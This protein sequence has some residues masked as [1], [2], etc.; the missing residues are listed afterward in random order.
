MDATPVHR[1]PQAKGPFKFF[2]FPSEI[3]IK[4]YEWLL[5][6]PDRVVDLNPANYKQIV[7]RIQCFLASRQT[8]AEASFVFYGS[9]TIRLFPKDRF[10]HTKLPLL[11]RLPERYRACISTIELRLGPHWSSPPRC[12][13]VDDTLGLEECVSLKMLK[14]FVEIDPSRDFFNGFRGRGNTR[15]TYKLFCTKMVGDIFSRVPSI[16]AVELDAFPG[17]GK[18]SPLLAALVGVVT[19]ASKNVSWGPL[20]GWGEEGDCGQLEVENALA[21]M[22]L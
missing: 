8:H 4:I 5:L 17:V 16:V 13:K 6:S 20:C 1:Q 21:R 2:D 22:H 15:D 3:R 11:A 19:Q 18:D 14:I 7:P 10:S 12:Q 9:Q